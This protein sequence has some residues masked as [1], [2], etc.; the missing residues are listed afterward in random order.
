MLCCVFTRIVLFCGV[1]A[2]LTS[3]S[4][5][6]PW[7]SFETEPVFSEAELSQLQFVFRFVNVRNT[8]IGRLLH[9]NVDVTSYVNKL[10]SPHESLKAYLWRVLEE[11]PAKRNERTPAIVDKCDGDC[12]V[13]QQNQHSQV[14]GYEG[15]RRDYSALAEPVTNSVLSFAATQVL[16]ALYGDT[17]TQ[18]DFCDVSCGLL[19]GIFDFIGCEA[20]CTA[21]CS[22]IDVTNTTTVDDVVSQLVD[23]VIPSIEAQPWARESTAKLFQ[24]FLFKYSHVHFELQ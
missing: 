8:A 19:C 20:G 17:E 13:S 6:E 23:F 22:S 4:R 24:H 16:N 5:R 7:S 10:E 3:A 1:L 11:R 15:C 21:V 18:E 9:H 12:K 14:S 2:T